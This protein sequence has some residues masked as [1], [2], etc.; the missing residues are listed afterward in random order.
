MKKRLLSALLFSTI[1]NAT[2]Y[3]YEVSPMAG[4]VFPSSQRL[5]NHAAYGA[6][7]QYNGLDSLLKPELSVFWSDADYEYIK[8]HATD[9]WRTAINGVYNFTTVNSITP[10]AK[11]GLGYEHINDRGNG[12]ENLNHN[13]AFVDAGAGIKVAITDQIALKLEAIELLKSNHFDWDNSLL[14]MAGL[15]FAFGEKAQPA[16]PVTETPEPDTAS[17]PKPA[18]TPAPKPVVEAPMDSDGDGVFDAEDKC[19]NT[20]QGFKV[21]SDGCPLTYSFKVFFDFDSSRIKKEFRGTIEEFA[22]FMKEN[23]YVAEIQ[24]HTDSTGTD[25]YNQGLSERRANAVMK[26]LIEL[27]IDPKRLKAVGF[28][29]KQPLN[30]NSTKEKRQQNRQVVDKLSY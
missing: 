7:F 6:E 20:P 2:E 12:T 30:D 17:A 8:P 16:A 27:G 1:I 26:K 22:T 29:E 23:P 5:E 15:N 10:F 19:P 18:P 14:L 13:G 28:G 3:N 24:G 11:A 4:Y 25:E 21:D 9:I